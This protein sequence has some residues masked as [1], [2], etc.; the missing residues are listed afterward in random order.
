MTTKGRSM[1]AFARPALPLAAI[2]L[3][4]MAGAGR[5]EAQELRT[6]SYSRQVTDEDHIEV[7][8]LYGIGELTV[9]RG[10]AGV[11]YRARMRYHERFAT[12]IAEY[13]DGLLKFGMEIAEAD[14]LE[15]PWEVSS[16]T[17]ATDLELPSMDLE[18]PADVAMDLNLVFL[19]GKVDLDLTGMPIR[20]LELTNGGSE[21]EIRITELNPEPMR[22]AEINVGVADFTMVGLGNLNA[23]EVEVTAGLGDLTL[24]IDGAWPEGS[25]LSIGMG[26][27]ALRIHI[28]ESLGVRV[29]HESSFLTSLHA[30]GFVKAEDTYTSENWDEA[31][32]KLEIDLSATLGVV[33]F[34]WGS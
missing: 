19:G 18:L 12:P 2:L 30:D 27:G 14:D 11:L 17:R 28:P 1:R 6:V 8:I 24:G 15:P 21:S 3:A 34:V 13:D 20:N 29:E 25:L 16:E 32:R 10:D 31:G 33:E 7:E 22:S 5:V 9:R 23:R 26:V 4:G